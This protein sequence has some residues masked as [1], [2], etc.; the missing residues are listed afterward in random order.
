MQEQCLCSLLTPHSDLS[1]NYLVEIDPEIF[2]G[3][4][5]LRK[6]FVSK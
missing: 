1:S 4:S 6:L 2:N 3:L 5:S